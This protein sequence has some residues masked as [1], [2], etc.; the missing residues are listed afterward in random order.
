MPK[1]PRRWPT[2]T[3]GGDNW[4]ARDPGIP[5]IPDV[6]AFGGRYTTT[7]RGGGVEQLGVVGLESTI[8]SEG[9]NRDFVFFYEGMCLLLP[10]L[11]LS[12]PF[13]RPC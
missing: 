13:L 2:R 6:S 3:A 11:A 4:A 9:H 7:Y 12:F 8:F 10:L 5:K 1:I